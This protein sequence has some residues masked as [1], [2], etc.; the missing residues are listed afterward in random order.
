MRGPFR[1][2]V[3]VSWADVDRSTDHG[4]TFDQVNNAISTALGA[5]FGLSEVTAM[6]YDASGNLYLIVNAQENANSR[7]STHLL[8]STDDGDSFTDITPMLPQVPLIRAVA[9]KLILGAGGQMG[10]KTNMG[11]FMNGMTVGVAEGGR[12]A[13]P[14]TFALA[15]VYPNPFNPTATI[16]FTLPEAGR[17]HLAVYDVLGRE[18]ATLVHG[19]TSAGQQHVLFD[20]SHLASGIY[21]CRLEMNGSSAMR[22]MVL[23]K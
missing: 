23:M 18:V 15:P 14:S 3:A 7:P 4:A 16:A 1:V 6:Q 5:D 11:L 20:G 21:F 13:A 17:V 8:M 2:S 12:T 9:E 19:M 22:R 10:V